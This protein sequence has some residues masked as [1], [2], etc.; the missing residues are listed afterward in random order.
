[1]TELFIVSTPIG[2]LKDISQRAIETI[3]ESDVVIC[4]N[5]KHSL[6]LLNKLGIKKKLIS[7]H[8]YNEKGVISKV[9]K[10]FLNKQIA[11]I[12]DAGSP[13][14]SDPGFKFLQYSISNN[15]KISSV[16]GATALIPGLQLSGIPIN[17][18]NFLG[19]FPKNTSDMKEFIN[20]IKTSETTT[21]FYVSSHKV[22]KCLEFI[23]E[24]MEDRLISIAKELTKMNERVIRGT[25]IEIK[26]QLLKNKTSLK[27][28]FVIVVEG[29]SQKKSSAIN[30]IE[31]YNEEI[32]KLLSKF[33][34]T[35]VVEIVH[36]L[37]GITKNK[38]YKWALK[39]KRS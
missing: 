22:K 21:V 4:E 37:T 9:S 20:E 1:M 23:E 17:R 31:L 39:L 36:K 19:F 13:L 11:F 16:P 10:E 15:F 33:S 2:N 38:I 26:N 29:T 24:E 28:E 30:N 8:D 35:D 6:K 14:I 18:F 34:L 5:P 25:V 7:L 27:G 3:K 32:K 12:S